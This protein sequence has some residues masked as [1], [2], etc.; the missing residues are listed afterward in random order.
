M[1][2][3]RTTALKIQ[4]R[5]RE[6]EQLQTIKKAELQA[7]RKQAADA[8]QSAGGYGKQAKHT[9]ALLNDYVQ[10]QANISIAKE[11]INSD[12]MGASMLQAVHNCDAVQDAPNNFRT[13]KEAGTAIAAQA[14]AIGEIYGMQAALPDG[15]KLQ[16]DADQ[17]DRSMQA[18]KTKE[19]QARRR[20]DGLAE[21]VKQVTAELA[22][23][24]KMIAPTQLALTNGDATAGSMLLPGGFDEDS[25]DGYVLPLGGSGQGDLDDDDQ[26]EDAA[27]GEAGARGGAHQTVTGATPG[28]ARKRRRVNSPPAS[29]PK[30]AA[31]CVPDVE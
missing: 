31:K 3:P 19:I 26:D 11:K 23:M 22:E 9:K 30:S 13:S 16:K 7:A 8:H 28:N 27:G 14:T 5:L 15:K 25:N 29:E 4:D 24:R 17:A 20:R 12:P 21:D 2:T 10:Q 18:S 6:L 1:A